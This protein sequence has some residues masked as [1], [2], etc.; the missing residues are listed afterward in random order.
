M[1][2]NGGRVWTNAAQGMTN[3]FGQWIAHTETT[4]PDMSFIY[5]PGNSPTPPVTTPTPPVTTPTPPVTTPTTP[6]TFT[7]QEGHYGVNTFTNYHNASGL[8]QKI[9]SATYVRVYCKVYDPTIASVN[10][11]GYWY[12]IASSPWTNYYAPA[13][14]FMNGDPWNGPYT[15]NTDMT[16]PNC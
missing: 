13:N 8:G 12:R 10:P 7:E 1:E 5:S 9:P 2:M 11:D 4:G 6:P 15:H 16:V 14:T 3:E